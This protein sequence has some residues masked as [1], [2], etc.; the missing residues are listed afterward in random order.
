MIQGSGP[1]W[2]YFKTSRWQNLGRERRRW[3]GNDIHFQLANGA[4]KGE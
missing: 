4:A 2:F 3:T 1:K